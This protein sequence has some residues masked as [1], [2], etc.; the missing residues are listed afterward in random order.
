MTSPANGRPEF[1][2]TPKPAF[3]LALRNQDW[4]AAGALSELVDNSFGPGRGNA[5]F[6][7]ITYDI[8]HRTLVVRDDGEGMQAIGRLF[9]LGNTIG[10]M[11][12][13]I[14]VYG[15]GGTYALLWLADKVELVTM[16]DGLV[17]G[18][19]VDWPRCIKDN[20]FPVVSN[21]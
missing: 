4:T 1:D 2:C 15:S 11:V 6:V 3:L 7:Q 9:Q 5:N 13:D 16:R 12:G 14:G 19:T 20:V 21:R 18:D 10:R 17:S 8:T